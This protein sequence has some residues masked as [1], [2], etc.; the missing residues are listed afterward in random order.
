[1]GLVHAPVGKERLVGGDQ[2]QVMLIGQIHQG[3]LDA[4]LH[5]QV[6]AHEFHIGAA[7]KGPR[8]PGQH[9]F[10]LFGLSIGQ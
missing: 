6:V 5:F 1:M 9:N 10:R 4:V 2:R 8:Q 7:G 3:W